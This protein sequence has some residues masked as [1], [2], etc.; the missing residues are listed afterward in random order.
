[1]FQKQSPQDV[2]KGY[3][4][5]QM[6]TV[7]SHLRNQSRF[8]D[9]FAID[10]KLQALV[11]H[12][13]DK[14]KQ[15]FPLFE[16]AFKL[17]PKWSLY[18]RGS[19]PFDI[20]KSLEKQLNKERAALETL[21]FIGDIV[22]RDTVFNSSFKVQNIARD[23]FQK[24]S[25]RDVEKATIDGETIIVTPQHTFR[26]YEVFDAYERR[27]GS[28]RSSSSNSNS[29]N[30]NSSSSSQ[31]QPHASSSS[32]S[33]SSSQSQAQASS[34]NSNA[35]SG[36]QSDKVRLFHSLKGNLDQSR[37]NPVHMTK[38]V[39]LPHI[40]EAPADMNIS[41][42][43]WRLYHEV[44]A[45][46]PENIVDDDFTR[47]KGLLMRNLVLVREQCF[48]RNS[49]NAMERD[50]YNMIAGILVAF[51]QRK[52]AIDKVSVDQRA[53]LIE[54]YQR[55]VRTFL[56]QIGTAFYHCIDRKVPT[57]QKMYYQYVE[58]NLRKLEELQSQ[59]LEEALFKQLLFVRRELID[60]ICNQEIETDA[61]HAS[62]E[63]FVKKK[64][65]AEFNLAYPEI[66]G[67]AN[68]MQVYAIERKV[69]EVRGI[70]RRECT[71]KKY[72]EHIQKY[73]KNSQN[74]SFNYQLL[75]NWFQE[76]FDLSEQD[77][78]D[79]DALEFKPEAMHA[80]YKKMGV[81][82]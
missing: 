53:K 36:A 49:H 46:M 72:N 7:L 20:V 37:L 56:M 5:E 71:V 29:S 55:D 70:F 51:Q 63:R 54:S 30:S 62:T 60:H 1:M 76:T 23:L 45:V 18:L 61:H 11:T 10:A 16:V 14:V 12:I 35:A 34:S 21:D 28:L 80:F 73:L 26:Y 66:I 32:H 77:V 25:M 44:D 43:L 64:L 50:M 31:S 15:T 67:D 68:N 41:N 48:P 9:V 13:H 79:V 58:K 42:E 2:F 75:C 65:N 47:P 27:F 39:S 4:D 17:P 78:Y 19:K 74:K 40:P 52:A 22:L 59:S 38:A 57:T 8:Q 24:F 82:L 33:Q 81:I 6:I 69:D 3:S